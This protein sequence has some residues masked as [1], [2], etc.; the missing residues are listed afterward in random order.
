MWTPPWWGLAPDGSLLMLQ[1][2]GT[3]GIYAFDWEAP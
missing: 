2:V 3:W 1:S